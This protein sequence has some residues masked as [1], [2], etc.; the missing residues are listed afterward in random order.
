MRIVERG[1]RLEGR[2]AVAEE[3]SR[4]IVHARCGSTLEVTAADVRAQSDWE[5]GWGYDVLC[6][7][8]DRWFWPWFT[9]IPDEVREY[10]QEAAR[11]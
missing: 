9:P 7:V 3:W 8:C 2:R 11:G 4:T 5:G 10:A 6:P 1:T